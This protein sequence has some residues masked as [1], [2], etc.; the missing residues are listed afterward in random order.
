ML[1]SSDKTYRDLARLIRE[2]ADSARLLEAQVRLFKKDR[3][4]VWGAILPTLNVAVDRYCDSREPDKGDPNGLAGRLVGQ[5]GSGQTNKYVLPFLV[6]LAHQGQE[7]V[8]PVF[9][10]HGIDFVHPP[11]FDVSAK[12]EPVLRSS[13]GNLIS[14]AASVNSAISDFRLYSKNNKILF[15]LFASVFGAFIVTSCVVAVMLARIQ[16]REMKF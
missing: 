8:M 9:E 3:K 1:A 6:W 7:Y 16:S 5:I 2:S 15:T 4:F 11:T 10:F 13:P 14:V 12:M